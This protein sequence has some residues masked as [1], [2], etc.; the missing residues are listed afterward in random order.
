MTLFVVWDEPTPMP[1][2]DMSP[3]VPSGTPVW[4]RIDHYALLRAT[5]SILGI[6]SFLG[7]ATRASDLRP[8]FS[9]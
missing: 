9:L 7:R 4:T 5:E 2:I 1:F 6:S 3:T 8:V